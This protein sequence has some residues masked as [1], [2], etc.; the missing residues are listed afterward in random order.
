MSSAYRLNRRSFLR[1]VAGAALG[2]GALAALTSGSARAQRPDF[3]GFYD[4]DPVDAYGH[5]DPTWGV[6]VGQ[7]DPNASRPQR[8]GVYT[9]YNDQDSSDVHGYGDPRR[10]TP[11][12]NVQTG[13]AGPGPRPYN[14]VTDSDGGA[15]ADLAGHGR[16]ALPPAGAR[17]GYTGVSDS[18]SG[19]GADLGGYGRG[20]PRAGPA[21]TGVTDRDS[22][23]GADLGG[24]GRGPH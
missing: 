8:Q 22:G 20:A 17:P 5:G 24:H 16:G 7:P 14:G 12:T 4:R 23:P 13:Q 19:A 6:P 18:D 2:G 11:A 3:T 1:T 10:G 21:Y 9:G 15:G